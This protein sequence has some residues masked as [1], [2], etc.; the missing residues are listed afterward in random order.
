MSIIK[1]EDFIESIADSLQA[2]SYSHPRDF[3]LAMAKAYEKEKNQSAKDA[4]AQILINSRMA[5]MGQRP[6]CQDTGIIT[7]FLK[8]GMN[9]HFDSKLSVLEMVNEGVR[10]AYNNPDNPLRK[11]VLSD[12]AGKRQNT[13]D[14]T[15]A[16]VYTE[17]VPGEQV[18]VR[19]AAKGVGCG[20]YASTS[21]S[22][23]AIRWL[24]GWL[25]LYQN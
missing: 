21:P 16:V 3:I 22:T 25:K 18:D 5:A 10:R 13:G 11:S 4:M 17:L 7:V 14:N 1:E 2:I 12:P 6:I 24:T 19:L 9:C 15:P 20:T 23:Q 8:V